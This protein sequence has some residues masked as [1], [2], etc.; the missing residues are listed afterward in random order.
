MLVGPAHEIGV[1]SSSIRQFY[2]ENWNRKIPIMEEKYYEWNFI[3]A[4]LNALEDKC[5]V[6]IDDD[7]EILGVMGLNERTFFFKGKKYHGA[8]L[9]TWIVR[10]R[11]QK[12]GVGPAILNYLKS[13]YEILLGMGIT[14]DAVSIYLRNGF[15]FLNPVP[16]YM[17]VFNLKNIEHLAY[18]DN[19]TNKILR[20]WKDNYFQ[21]ENDYNEVE[22]S[23]ELIDTISTNATGLYNC[24]SRGVK[25]I[26]WRY[27][28]HPTYSYV[29]KTFTSPNNFEDPA[30]LVYRI[31]NLPGGIKI[32][33][34]LDLFGSVN[35]MKSV[36]SFIDIK[37]PEFGI[38]FVD[39]YS[40]LGIHQGIM[41]S[42]G[43]FSLGND[44]FFSFPHLFNPIE[45]RNPASNSL[46]FWSKENKSELFNFSLNYFSKQDC[47]FDRP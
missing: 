35:A 20:Y 10:V 38:D 36:L 33:H 17:K 1:S 44:D 24:F 34:I 8:E 30:L 43:W 7:G 22:V 21:I 42:Q 12:R 2:S 16:R 14:P 11:A 13:Q 18:T 41:L 4:P 25:E 40:T 37:F 9:T 39:F 15:R 29:I 45:L 27:K 28:Q 31:Q 3:Q 46:V 6:A 19:R 26:E 23:S 5:C 32:A 47:D